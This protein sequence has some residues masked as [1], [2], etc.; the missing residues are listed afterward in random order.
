MMSTLLAKDIHTLVT[1][2]DER[3]EINNGILFV[4]DGVIEF[5]GAMASVNEATLDKFEQE[6]DK[7]LSLPNHIIMPGMVNT[8][9]HMY[10]SLTRVIAQDKELFDWLVTLYP[11]WAKLTGKMVHIS[12][13][14]AMAELILSG[15]TSSSDHLYIYPN[16]VKLE[17]TIHAAQAIGMRFHPTRGSM[18]V[19]ESKGGLPPDSV[20]EQEDA[21][22]RETRNIIET[23]HDAERYSMLRIGVAPCSPFSVSQDLMRESATLARS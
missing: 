9:H 4:R 3:Q 21:I 7:I 13:Q 18:S 10:Q 14:V 12:A 2:D 8:H 15:C 6:A 23:Y 5:V 22:L 17:D 19:G 1:M 20:V 11:I 16:D